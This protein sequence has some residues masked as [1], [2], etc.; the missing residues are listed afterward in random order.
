MADLTDSIPGAPEG[1]DHSRRKFLVVATTV[2]GAV[3]AAFT[4]VPFIDSWT[5]SES[6][7]A[8]GGATEVDISKVDVGQM[9]ITSWRRQPIFILRR[10]PAQLQ[11]LQQSSDTEL[12]RDPNSEVDQQ[13]EYAR[14][15]H[16]S[17]MPE[18]LIVVGICTHLGCVPR[19]VPGPGE[20]LGPS[21][22]GGYFCPCH[23]SRYDLSARV[24][25]GV[26][27][28]YNLPV[29]PHRFVSASLL[30]IGENP[31]GASFDFG[32]IEQ[33]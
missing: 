14:N 27:A 30:R 4:A 26:P 21:W 6:A 2:C 33:L 17:I 29:P 23:G 24:F 5:P 13:P 25:K 9:I 28:P 16:R 32:S 18:Y 22:H 3:G 19:Y 11:T 7:R 1:A 12:L 10:T 15:W 8:L 31:P 20:N